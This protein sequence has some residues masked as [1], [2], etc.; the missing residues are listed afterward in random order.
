MMGMTEKELYK[1]RSKGL[2]QKTEREEKG[3]WGK[4]KTVFT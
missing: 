2:T 3:G 4:D 1:K